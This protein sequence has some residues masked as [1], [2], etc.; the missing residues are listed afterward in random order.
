MKN[1]FTFFA[2]LKIAIVAVCCSLNAMAQPEDK[3]YLKQANSDLKAGDYIPDSKYGPVVT[4]SNLTEALK[5]PAIYKSARFS[6]SGLTKFPEQVFSFP[7]IEELDISQNTIKE[8]PSN[9]NELQNLKELH[10]NKN[11]LTSIGNE[12]ILCSKLEVI[13]IQN[14][15]LQSISK[16]IE[17]VISLKEVT[18]GEVAKN[19]KVPVELWNLT[20]LVKLK[21]T[22]A[23]LTEIPASIAGLKRLGELCLANNSIS[24][25]PEELYT[26]T[27][28][29]YINLGG[30]KINSV[31]GSIKNLEHLYYLGVYYNPLKAF[32]EEIGNLKELAFLSCWKTNIPKSEVEKFRKKLPVADIHDTETDLH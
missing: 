11:Q 21:I 13:Q 6:N 19:C 5:N 20:N 23:G 22:N 26:L 24:K 2:G 15:P 1:N 7:N 32:P 29:T 31:S 27:D 4:P 25:I 17:K 16:D 9:L 30:N 8:L 18:I 3:S 28:I 10:V 14:N 12:I